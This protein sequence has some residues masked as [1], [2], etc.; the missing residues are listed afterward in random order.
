MIDFVYTVSGLKVSFRI[1][2][3]V[4]AEIQPDWD[5]GVD[6]GKSTDKHPTFNYEESGFYTVTLTLGKEKCEKQVIVSEFS[7]THLS[8]SIYIL[9]NNYIP[10]YIFNGMTSSDKSLYINKWQLYLQPLVNHEIPLEQYSNELYYEGLENQLVMELAVFDFLYTKIVNMLIST[11]DSLGKINGAVNEESD[12]LRGDRIKQITTG[13]T[14]VQYF[15]K[16]SESLS[17]LFKSYS[18]SLKPGGILDE[19]RNNICMLAKRL[20]IYLPIC[21]KPIDSVVPQIV[22]HRESGA[23]GGPNPASLVLQ[24]SGSLI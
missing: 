6:N 15:D 9:I 18:E 24:G 21:S 1:L 13:P 3:K 7:K 22:N 20:D 2:T 5:F 8:D 4:P 10:G 14:E 17:S 16:V 12:D 19:L 23:I 11:G